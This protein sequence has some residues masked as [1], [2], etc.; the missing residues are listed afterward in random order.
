MQRPA[1]SIKVSTNG[2]RVSG[3]VWTNGSRGLT[4]VLCGG[5]VGEG[6]SWPGEDTGDVVVRREEGGARWPGEGPAMK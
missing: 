4:R 6:W 3:L 2:S 5:W 1:D